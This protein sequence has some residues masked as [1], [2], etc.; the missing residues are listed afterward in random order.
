MYMILAS[1]QNNP[2]ALKK[3]SIKNKNTPLYPA[4]SSTRVNYVYFFLSE[5]F[6]EA[7]RG[8]KRVSI[9]ATL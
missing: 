9:L 4:S 8:F 3:F 2:P 7:L 6:I 1:I 5:K